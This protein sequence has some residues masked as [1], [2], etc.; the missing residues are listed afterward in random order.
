MSWLPKVLY[1]D[2]TGA[3]YNVRHEWLTFPKG[4]LK[5]HKTK[6]QLHVKQNNITDFPGSQNIVEFFYSTFG[7][8]RMDCTY[9]SSKFQEIWIRIVLYTGLLWVAMENIHMG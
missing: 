6:K 4:A 7:S 8:L 5:A 1:H 3:D 2:Q 9:I